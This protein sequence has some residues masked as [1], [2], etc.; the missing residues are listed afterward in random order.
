MSRLSSIKKEKLAIESQLSQLEEQRQSN[1]EKTHALAE[2]S[3]ILIAGVENKLF[4]TTR[5]KLQKQTEE[6][7]S[8]LPQYPPFFNPFWNTEQWDNHQHE[9]LFLPDEI[10]VGY[11]VEKEHEE[12]VKEPRLKLPYFAPFIGRE[13]TLVISYNSENEDFSLKKI[14]ALVERIAVTLPNACKFT[15]LDPAK[16]GASFPMQRNLQYTRDVDNETYRTLNEI[17]NDISRINRECLSVGTE[18][19]EKLSPQVITDERFEFIFA[20]N[21]PNGYGR[22]SI[23]YLQKISKS[24]PRAGKYL[25]LHH[26]TEAQFPMEC[27]MKDFTNLHDTFGPALKHFGTYRCSPTDSSQESILAKIKNSKPKD[28]H[29]EF[30]E[31]TPDTI[32]TFWKESA[33]HEV[34]VPIGSQGASELRELWFGESSDGRS[35]SH[36]MIAGMPGSGKSNLY[37]VFICGLVSRYSP[38]E[39]QLYLVDGKQGVEFQAYKELPHAQVISLKTTPQLARSVLTELVDI[40]ERR[41]SIFQETGCADLIRYREAGSPHGNLPRVILV[42]DEYQTFF[43]NDRYGTASNLMATLAA[44]G[45]SFGIHMFVGSQSF[46]VANMLNQSGIFGNM[47]L[48]AAMKMSHSHIAALSEFNKKGKDRI[49]SCD[50]PG[51]IVINDAAGD[52]SANTSG[53]VALLS[54]E[55]RNKL[56]ANIQEKASSKAYAQPKIFNG[57]A[58]PRLSENPQLNY[59]LEHSGQRP[60]PQQWQHYAQLAEHEGGLGETNWFTAQRPSVLWLGQELNVHGQAKVILRR[61]PDENILLIGDFTA[62]RVGILA[63]ALSALPLNHSADNVKLYLIDRSIEGSPWH[64]ALTQVAKEQSME[65]NADIV[66][67]TS[68]EELYAIL[69]EIHNELTKRQGLAE[70]DV[71]GEASIYFCIHECQHLTALHKQTSKFGMSENSPCGELLFDIFTKGPEKG[72]HTILSFN[73]LKSSDQI[74]ETN[75]L[76]SFRHRIALQ[77]SEDESFTLLRSRNAA[78]LQAQGKL[79]IQAIYSN[80]TQ[81]IE[82]IF[83]PYCFTEQQPEELLND[84][85]ALIEKIQKW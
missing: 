47:H 77:M 28:T 55:Q 68:Q 16:L 61:L 71:A 2:K 42:V 41:N 14:Q 17:V 85:R 63:S 15:L 33:T 43:E 75:E 50:M 23:E 20:A 11:H 18:S 25:I 65:L 5:S 58:Q 59:L 83:K 12:L 26:D 76:K 51:K 9:Q 6:L 49:R 82:N 46:G 21:F 60:S 40:M 56:L 34:R 52:D 72:I 37:H 10:I 7:Q 39:V 24:G 81:N 13:K 38:E 64:G 22:R 78:T 27:G 8:T 36:G 19:F 57:A 80:P 35:C 66:T 30:S 4:K 44:Q 84:S 67:S 69:T 3:N 48:R 70:R 1:K 45:R 74:L 31:I 79:P 53:K 29:L 32:D 62:A 54:D 73:G